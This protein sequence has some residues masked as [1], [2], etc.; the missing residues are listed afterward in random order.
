MVWAV[1]P[2]GLQRPWALAVRLQ[3]QV[4]QQALRCIAEPACTMHVSVCSCEVTMA[5]AAMCTQ[6]TYCTPVRQTLHADANLLHL[7]AC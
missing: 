1:L 5:P 6:F 3:R 4:L 7:S 2:A